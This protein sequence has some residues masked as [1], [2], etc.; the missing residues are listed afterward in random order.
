MRGEGGERER[1]REGEGGESVVHQIDNFKIS[2]DCY[3]RQK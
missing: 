3:F 2:S 1:K